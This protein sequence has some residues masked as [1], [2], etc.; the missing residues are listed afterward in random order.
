MLTMLITHWSFFFFFLK[1]KGNRDPSQKPK[2]EENTAE[3]TKLRRQE[4]AE[5]LNE[6]SDTTDMPDLESE[7]SAT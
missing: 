5:E 4:S 7:E 3:T 2:F 6:Q 1:K